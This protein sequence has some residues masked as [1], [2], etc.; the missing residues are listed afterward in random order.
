LPRPPI[1]KSKT[2]RLVIVGKSQDQRDIQ[3]FKEICKRE[4]KSV[5]EQALFLLKPYINLH[6]PGNNQQLIAKIL[7]DGKPYVAPKSCS[8]CSK[9]AVGFVLNLSSGKEKT[10]CQR[11]L[12][13]AVQSGKWKV[14]E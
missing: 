3:D 12:D 2:N 8:F 9:P 6:R 5:T 1:P 10:V 14:K 11:H 4:G 7:Q 13:S